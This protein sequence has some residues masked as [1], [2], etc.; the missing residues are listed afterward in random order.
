MLPVYFALLAFLW[1]Y[2]VPT[3]PPTFLL[4]LESVTAITGVQH[5]LVAGV[6]PN[7]CAGLPGAMADTYCTTIPCPGM[8]T[9]RATVDVQGR[10]S[11][12]ITFRVRDHAC[13]QV[14]SPAL[15][16]GVYQGAGIP[17]GVPCRS[18]VPIPP[19]PVVT[20]DTP[21]MTPLTPYVATPLTEAPIIP[22][23]PKVVA[24]VPHGPG[25]TPALPPVRVPVP[26]RG[27]TDP[28]PT[29]PVFV[30]SGPPET[31]QVSLPPVDPPRVA[32]P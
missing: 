30:P 15:V 23:N 13:R 14:E 4:T 11:N 1:E 16:P 19:P 2:A 3:P 17:P 27:L 26:P 28:L 7:D 21:S 12:T 22:H 31:I 6:V 9:F 29:R 32:C 18:K 20:M 25:A 24:K 8:G 5:V 10:K